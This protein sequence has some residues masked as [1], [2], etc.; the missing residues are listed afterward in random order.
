MDFQ[1]LSINA[2]GAMMTRKNAV[3]AVPVAGYGGD[4]VWFSEDGVSG[5][6]LRSNH[7]VDVAKIPYVPSLW[8]GHFE[9]VKSAKKITICSIRGGDNVNIGWFPIWVMNSSSIR[10]ETADAGVVSWQFCVQFIRCWIVHL[11]SR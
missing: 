1:C 8:S 5:K 2:C 9:V 6:D 7:G 11:P 3:A 4:A 10:M